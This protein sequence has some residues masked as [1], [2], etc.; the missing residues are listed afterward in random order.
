MKFQFLPEFLWIFLNFHKKCNILLISSPL[1]TEKSMKYS[2]FQA[3]DFLKFQ[4]KLNM[5]KISE[6]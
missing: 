2:I 4:W 5:L 6:I 1:K 3:Q